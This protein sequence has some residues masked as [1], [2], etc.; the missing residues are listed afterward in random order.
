MSDI[1]SSKCATFSTYDA[2]QHAATHSANYCNTLQHT[3]MQ[4]NN[5]LLALVNA[6]HL[7]HVTRRTLVLS[8]A[9]T[10]M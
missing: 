4:T 1:I 5:I 9:A 6:L 8:A 3:A 10:D 7:S 2:P